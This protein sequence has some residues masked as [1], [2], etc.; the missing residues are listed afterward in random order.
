MEKAMPNQMLL[1]IN[2]IECKTTIGCYD[3][4]QTQ[5]QP[6]NADIILDLGNWNSTDNL[7]DTADYAEVNDFVKDKINASQHKLLESLATELAQ[8]ILDNYPL[9]LEVTITLNKPNFNN[10]KARQTVCSYKK[11]RDYKI[12]LALGSNQN[13]PSQQL[14]NATTFLGE[15]V[16]D[17]KIAP[18]YKSSPQ[19]FIDQ[20][21]YYNTCI[22]GYTH[23]MPAELLIATKK[24]EK[25]MGKQEQFTNGPRI[26]DI[27]IIFFAKE[28][29]K[30]LFL[31]IPHPRMSQR[32]FVLQPLADIEPEWEHPELNKSVSTLLKELS[33]NEQ[34]ILS[35]G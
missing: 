28:T 17:I 26:I 31:T 5:I 6:V 34:F 22:S 35:R 13:N 23:L 30:K 19:G 16:H 2:G 25:L 18:I 33:P 4:E 8:Q 1:E 7:I 29:Y 15:F 14:I 20:N 32:D 10:T 12:A 11:K 21:D 24:V 3:Y 9:V 27:D